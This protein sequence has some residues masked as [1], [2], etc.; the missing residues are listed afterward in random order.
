MPPGAQQ[1]P[2]GGDAQMDIRERILVEILTNG[3]TKQA[4]IQNR[5]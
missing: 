3:A 5:F 1:V 2:D 4:E